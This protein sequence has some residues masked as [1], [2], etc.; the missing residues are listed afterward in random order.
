M[1]K[2][3]KRRDA[4]EL[5]IMAVSLVVIVSLFFVFLYLRSAS[6]RERDPIHNG[7]H[8]LMLL[9]GLRDEESGEFGAMS[10]EIAD[11]YDLRV[12][13]MSASTVSSQQEMLSLVP[14]TDVDAVLFWGVSKADADYARELAA[15]R[16]AGVPV[17]MIDH[18]FE[19]KTLRASFIGSGITSELMVINETL[20]TAG[21]APILI[22]N[23]S[24]AGSSDL[25]E[26]LVLRREENP[27]FNPDQI[28]SERLKSFVENHPNGYYADEY[29]QIGTEGGGMAA[30]N[31]RLIETL[32][33]AEGA[34]LF[35]SLNETLTETLAVALET[36]TLP[37]N[38][39][40]AVIGYG[41]EAD[42]RQYVERGIISE[43]LVSDVLYS[44][45]IGLRYL[46]DILR[47]FYVPSTL[48]SGVKLVTP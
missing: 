6:R 31:L 18:D 36:D 15:C 9:P 3:A 8:I 26:L 21:D 39:L 40:G 38:A 42:L 16:E 44:S 41:R 34:E 29:I 33:R 43:L 5:G 13:T 27:A 11:R 46:N 23:Y 10:R 2:K 4:V 47:G 25:Y 32:S 19:D 20:Y 12:E 1:V 35:F 24:P 17:V 45:R 22:G 7:P 48:D 30:L 37:K 14:M 28:Q